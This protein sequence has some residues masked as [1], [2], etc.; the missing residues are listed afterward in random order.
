MARGYLCDGCT[1]VNGA[2]TSNRF[3]NGV[4]EKF[5]AHTLS[6]TLHSHGTR[7]EGSEALPSPRHAQQSNEYIWQ[8][9]SHFAE[10]LPWCKIKKKTINRVKKCPE[11]RSKRILTSCSA[12][13][14]CTLLFCKIRITFLAPATT[15]ASIRKRCNSS[16]MRSSKDVSKS[17][18]LLSPFSSADWNETHKHVHTAPFPT[19]ETRTAR[20]RA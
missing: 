20:K 9:N 17:H 16:S 8:I 12:F 6:Y 14:S 1:T 7:N 5:H 18:P 19:R 10:R 4:E 11:Y 15:A 3:M 2:L 13:L